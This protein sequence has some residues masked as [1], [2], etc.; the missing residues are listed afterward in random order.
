MAT[1]EQMLAARRAYGMT[2]KGSTGQVNGYLEQEVYQWSPEKLILKTYDLFIVACKREESE[3]MTNILR[4]LMAALDF[5]YSEQSTRLFRMY[6]Y[7]QE[8]VRKRKYDEA[9]TI[10]KELRATWAQAFN[11]EA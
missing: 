4:S 6:E 5:E 8:C 10:I 11:L 7:C 2:K 3:K 9:L 1:A